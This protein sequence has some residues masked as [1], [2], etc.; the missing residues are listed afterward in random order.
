MIKKKKIQ[1]FQF[2]TFAVDLVSDCI[3]FVCTAY[4]T[5]VARVKDL[6]PTFPSKQRERKRD[7]KGGGEERERKR[8]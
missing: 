3:A 1:Y 7:G 6:M 8:I 5:I 2:N 4:A